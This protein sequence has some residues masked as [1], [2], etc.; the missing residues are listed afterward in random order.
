MVSPT[1]ASLGK[2]IINCGILFL[3]IHFPHNMLSEFVHSTVLKFIPGLAVRIWDCKPG[4][5]DQVRAGTE[6]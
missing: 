6:F 1:L 3:N 2:I 4:K 5:D